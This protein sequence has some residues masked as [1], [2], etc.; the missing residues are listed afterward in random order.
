MTNLLVMELTAARGG[1]A[2]WQ[3]MVGL[4]LA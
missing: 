2:C 3:T 4:L 1:F